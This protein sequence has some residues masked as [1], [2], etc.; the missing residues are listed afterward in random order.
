[1]FAGFFFDIHIIL[2]ETYQGVGEQ[3]GEQEP[4]RTFMFA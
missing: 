1:V 4:G 3:T 2:G